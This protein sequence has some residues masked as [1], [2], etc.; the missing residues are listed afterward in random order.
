MP[1]KP[2]MTSRYFWLSL[3]NKRT[4][5]ALHNCLGLRPMGTLQSVGFKLGQRVDTVLMQRPSGEGSTTLPVKD[6]GGK[7]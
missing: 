4:P 5:V 6:E 1:T 7:E 2:S 3:K